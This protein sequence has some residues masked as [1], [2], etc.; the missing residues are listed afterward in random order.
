[1]GLNK[2]DIKESKMK[3][4][5]PFKHAMNTA[6]IAGSL[7]FAGAS[8]AIVITSDTDAN[9]LATAVTAG[10]GLTVISATLSGH[11]SAAGGPV[12]SGTYTNASGTYGIG[13]GI[14]LSSGDVNDY[15]DGPNTL[16]GNTTVY[17]VAATGGQEALLD[18][19]TGGSLNHF[20]VTQLDI[21]FT[22][23]TG[24]VFFLVTF[25]SDEYPEYQDSSFIDAF[26]LYLNGTNIAFYNGAP[27][28][29]DHPLM[30]TCAGTELD[31]VLPCSGPMLFSGTGLDI[32]SN[33]TLTF[34]IADS[35]D[36]QLDSTAYINSLSG[37]NPIPEP[38]SLALLGIGLVG[39]GA[40]RRRKI[41]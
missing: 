9:S 17:G 28:N 18:P 26:G 33:H 3:L 36:Q 25:G 20:D 14:V 40:M 6:A 41:A 12:S 10:G 29:I 31:G 34:I 5:T 15:N 4:S 16:G 32:G 8:H 2:H 35:G 11:A 27:I 7:T 1:V 13:P 21:T 37:Q 23:S 30:T 39:L 19:I 24:N 22:T 38:A